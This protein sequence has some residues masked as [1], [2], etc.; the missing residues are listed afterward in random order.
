MNTYTLS[1]PEFIRFQ[2]AFRKFA[3]NKSIDS[4]DIVLYNL[5]RGCAIDR[6]FSPVTNATK[7]N[8]GHGAFQSLSYAKSYAKARL[9]GRHNKYRPSDYIKARFGLE[10]T[11]EQVNELAGRL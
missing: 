10:L 2:T 7:L 8:N 9:I 4:G 6:G 1:K 11:D 5:I 3:N